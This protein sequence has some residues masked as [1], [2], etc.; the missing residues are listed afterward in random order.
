MSQIN[1]KINSRDYVV[2]CEDGEEDHLAFLAQ[3]IN[4]RVESLVES[5]GQVGEARLLLMAALMVADELTEINEEL[6]I[7]KEGKTK[8]TS[9]HGDEID[10]KCQRLEDIAL[11]LETS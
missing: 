6:D 3:Y 2:A 10:K 9:H 4:Q 5:V 7:L 11:R 1:L 8:K